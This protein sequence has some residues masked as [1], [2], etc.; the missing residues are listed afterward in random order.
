MI[1]EDLAADEVVGRVIIGDLWR[2]LKIVR[3]PLGT[4]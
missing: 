1:V 2:Q 4:A 3:R